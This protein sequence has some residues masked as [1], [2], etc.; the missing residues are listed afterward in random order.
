MPGISLYCSTRIFGYS[1][2]GYICKKFRTA[3][4]PSTVGYNL[5]YCWPSLTGGT[6]PT[7]WTQYNPGSGNFCYFPLN[8]AYIGNDEAFRQCQQMGADMTYIESNAERTTLEGNG[9]IDVTVNYALNAH[10]FRY[11]PYG[12]PNDATTS[13]TWSNGVPV[14]NHYGISWS[15]GEPNDYCSGAESCFQFKGG[16]GDMMNDICCYVGET[17]N[18]VRNGF[19]SCKRPLCGQSCNLCLYIQFA[20]QLI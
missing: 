9:I 5:G 13:F 17:G 10:R 18:T 6:C 15:P 14:Y 19:S 3:P 20:F 7:G 1:S 11:G 12:L 16:Y 4:Y 8:T 2:G